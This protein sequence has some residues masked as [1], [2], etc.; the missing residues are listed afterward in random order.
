MPFL[1]PQPGLI[2][3]YAL[4]LL[5][6]G[7]G[8]MI[9]TGP[10]S[11]DLSR[12]GKLGD[13]FYHYGEAAGTNSQYAFFSPG[14]SVQIRVRFTVK[15]DQGST[16]FVDFLSGR[17]RE[18]DLRLGDISDQ[19]LTIA[20]VK[21]PIGRKLQR[22]LA[23]SLAAS[24]FSRHPNARSIV[25]SI[26]EFIPKPLRAKEPYPPSQWRQVYSIEFSRQKRG[27]TT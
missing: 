4:V 3:R 5:L 7:H 25:V 9:I 13:V 22:S 14:I 26:E 18:M 19:F 20:N 2:A 21:D 17:N 27:A 24:V 1:R 12:F 23:A 15:K 11:V 6:I 16:E 8:L 10:L